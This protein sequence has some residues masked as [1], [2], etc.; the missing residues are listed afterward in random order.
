[1]LWIYWVIDV[2]GELW[3]DPF[4]GCI[5]FSH[6]HKAIWSLRYKRNFEKLKN[7]SKKK[8]AYQ[9]YT[10]VFDTCRCSLFRQVHPHIQ[11]SLQEDIGRDGTDTADHTECAIHMSSFRMYTR[12]CNQTG[13]TSHH[14]HTF[15]RHVCIGCLCCLLKNW[16]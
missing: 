1:M 9:V 6:D 4:K 13:W 8:I 5:Y 2:F 14:E 7:Q 15:S 16:R 12:S 10:L 11:S 3:R